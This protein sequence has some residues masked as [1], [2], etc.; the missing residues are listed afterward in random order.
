MLLNLAKKRKTIRNFKSDVPPLSDIIYAIEIAKEA[1]SGMNSQPWCFLIVTDPIIKEKIK[2]SS[3]SAE[4]VFYENS[5]GKLKDFLIKNSI[6]WQKNFLINAPYLILIFS[7]IRSP[8]SK[9]ST[10]ISIGYFLL[11]LEEKNLST[12]TYTPPN[13]LQIAEIVNAPK[14]YRLEVILPIGYS[15]ETKE[16]QKRKNTNEIIFYNTF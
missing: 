11:A 10:W 1:P 3:E 16:K 15:N 14:F 4:K 9:E 2:N 8:F 13:P 12:V 5:K 7:D 6:T